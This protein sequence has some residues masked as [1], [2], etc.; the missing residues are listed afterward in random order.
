MKKQI[1]K[2][3]FEESGKLRALMPALQ[4]K[5]YFNYGGQGP[6]P[7]PSLKAITNSW[8]KIQELGPFTNDVWPY[9]ANE[10]EATR[11]QLAKMC[12]V[13]KSRICLTENVTSGCILPLLGL[14]FSQGD[15]LLISDCEHPGVVSA[16]QE[17]AR[18]QK[19]EIDILPV[20]QL[21][22]GAIDKKNTELDLLKNLKCYLQEKTRLVVLSHILWNTGQI[23]PIAAVAETLVTH[24]QKPYLLVDAAQ[25]FGQIPIQGDACNADIYAFTGHKWAYGPEGLGGIAISERVLKES[26]PTVIGWR[27]LKN[28]GHIQ[29]LSADP[30]HLDSRRFEIAT[31]CIPLLAG[32]RCSLDLLEGEGSDTDR[33]QRIEQ[34]SAQLW[35]QLQDIK[36][37]NTILEGPPPA[38]LVSFSIPQTKSTKG[39]VKMLGEQRLWIRDLEDPVC[40]RACVH[41]TSKANEITALVGAIKKIDIDENFS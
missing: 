10:I 36:G 4:N 28:E 32:L 22:K 21:R 24:P 9:I 27:S 14:P 33:L 37:V 1:D 35:E 2:F 20:K 30:F 38:G 41:V 16:C 39:V 23:I 3:Q 29:K 25:S 19:L 12:G 34:L 13:P 8:Q 17:L 18:R 7:T 11:K 31:S 15:R 26:K 5:K 6:L 40:L